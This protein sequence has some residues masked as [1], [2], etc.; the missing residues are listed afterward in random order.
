LIPISHSRPE[1]HHNKDEYNEAFPVVPNV[2][3][4]RGIGLLLVVTGL[5]QCLSIGLLSAEHLDKNQP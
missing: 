2:L 5:C 3:H 1:N 4:W